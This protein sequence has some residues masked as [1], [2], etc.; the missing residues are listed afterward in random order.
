MDDVG[1]D[2]VGQGLMGPALAQPNDNELAII[3]REHFALAECNGPRP[4]A[5]A[6]PSCACASAPGAMPG[7]SG[8]SFAVTT[9]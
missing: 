2:A 3:T 9:S 1:D 5:R 4:T 7:S 8:R 6:P